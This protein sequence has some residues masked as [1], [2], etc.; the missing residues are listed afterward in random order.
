[1][2]DLNKENILVRVRIMSKVTSKLQITLPKHIAEQYGIAPG[3]DIQ[4]EAAGDV[5]RI[6]PGNRKSTPVF[7]IQ[8]RLRL[9][10]EAFERQ[11]QR[12]SN[13]QLPSNPP[14]ERGW[15]REDLYDRGKSD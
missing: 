15:R 12:A 9:F 4:F 8:E 5:I 6:V 11:R 1:M 3:D 7:T 13:M 2:V 10:D 14:I